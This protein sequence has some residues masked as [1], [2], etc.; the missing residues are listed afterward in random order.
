MSRYYLPQR[1]PTVDKDGRMTRPWILF[2]QHLEETVTVLEALV[3]SDPAHA[4]ATTL[5]LNGELVP[6]STATCRGQFVA[7]L[8]NDGD[9]R[10]ALT[11]DWA[12][13]NQHIVTL[14]ENVTLAFL[15]PLDGARYDL[16][17]VQAAGGGYTVAWPTEVRWSPSAPTVST[18]AS[19]VDVFHFLYVEATKTYYGWYD[20]DF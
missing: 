12:K 14:A 16:V 11:V 10:T 20:Q 4:T 1:E 13:G 7:P 5:A 15:H 9:A 18:D 6:F 2:L 19:A 3:S 17:V 8:V